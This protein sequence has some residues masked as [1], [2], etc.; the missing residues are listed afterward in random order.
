MRRFVERV[1]R[2]GR[3][4]ERVETERVAKWVAAAIWRRGAKSAAH[5]ADA[6]LSILLNPHFQ[7]VGSEGHPVA[8]T[9]RTHL[10]LTDGCG[11]AVHGGAVG[12]GVGNLPRATPIGDGEVALGEQL[13]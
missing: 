9:Q 3:W 5:A 6:G 12:R 4:R 13:L 10:G 8:V 1:A 2:R 7:F 11:I